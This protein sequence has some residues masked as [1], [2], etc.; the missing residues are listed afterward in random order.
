MGSLMERP[1]KKSAAQTLKLDMH[2]RAQ[3]ANALAQLIVAE[4]VSPDV[5]IPITAGPDAHNSARQ[6]TGPEAQIN[7][8]RE[9]SIQFSLI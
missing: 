6:I 1:L 7:L 9:S 5:F 8:V 4:V 3:G 2:G